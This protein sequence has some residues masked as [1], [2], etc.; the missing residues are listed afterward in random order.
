MGTRPIRELH[1]RIEQLEAPPKLRKRRLELP[2]IQ[3]Y[4]ERHMRPDETGRIIMLFGY[5]QRLLGKMLG[6]LHLGSAQMVELQAAE[7]HETPGLI[8]ELP[9]EL[10]GPCIGSADVGVAADL[11]GEQGG[12]HLQIELTLG[13]LARIR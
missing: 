13:P 11:S 2:P 4:A 9:T 3:Q 1:V 10:P 6:L 12:T 7:R 8:P 5:A